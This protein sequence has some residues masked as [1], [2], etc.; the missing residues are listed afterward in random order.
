MTMHREVFSAPIYL[1]L[2]VRVFVPAY[3][4]VCAFRAC[5]RAFSSQNYVT[6]H[7]WRIYSASVSVDQHPL[8]IHSFLISSHWIDS[9][10]NPL[11]KWACF[12]LKWKGEPDTFGSNNSPKQLYLWNQSKPLEYSSNAFTHVIHKIE[13]T[14]VLVAT[15]YI[16]SS[17]LVKSVIM[18]SRLVLSLVNLN[19]A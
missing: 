8:I 18:F 19:P 7:W 11:N 6:L 9:T 3:V 15:S 12:Y 13:M 5:V 14:F 16:S 10:D 1:R 4:R 17:S 2:C